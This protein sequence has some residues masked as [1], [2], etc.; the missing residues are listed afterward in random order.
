VIAVGTQYRKEFGAEGDVAS[1][2]AQ[3]HIPVFHQADDIPSCDIIYSVQYH[4]LLKAVHIAQAQV[5]AVN[6]HLAPLPE[7]RGCNQ[8]SFAIMDEAKS[9]GV[10]IHE[11]DTRIDHGALLFES[12]F[13][14][15]PGIWVSELYQMTFDAAVALFQ[16]SL[17]SIINGAYEKIP[18][19]YYE[20]T[21]KAQI[22]YRKE[23][24]TLKCIDLNQEEYVIGKTLRATY[25]PGFE[26]PYCW[27]NGRKVLLIPDLTSNK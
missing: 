12:R 2:A 24:E 1:L 26:P 15:P 20:Q 14:I 7:Y 5:I 13:A 19:S 10:T 8:F 22:H 3:H 25:M 6:L 21:R 27:V 23:I 18:Q 4:Q 17:A 16:S 9:F 11:I